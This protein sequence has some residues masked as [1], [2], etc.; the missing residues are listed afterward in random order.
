MLSLLCYDHDPVSPIEPNLLM[1]K[2]LFP[3][4]YLRMKRIL[5]CN[6]SRAAV[7]KSILRQWPGV[8]SKLDSKREGKNKIKGNKREQNEPQKIDLEQAYFYIRMV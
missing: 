1:L 3:P 5:V 4:L 6:I 7:F 8:L 2:W